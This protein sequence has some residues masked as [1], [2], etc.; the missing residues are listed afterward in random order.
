MA[1][2]LKNDCENANTHTY[3]GVHFGGVGT[4]TKE[5]KLEL[6]WIN[7]AMKRRREGFETSPVECLPIECGQSDGATDALYRKDRVSQSGPDTGHVVTERWVPASG[8]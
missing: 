4:F 5:I 6:M 7:S 2:P 3:G 8:Q 1:N